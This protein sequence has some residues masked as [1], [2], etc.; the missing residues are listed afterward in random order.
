[1]PEVAA[2]IDRDGT[3]CRH[4]PYLSSV[5]NFEL[6][7]TAAPGVRRLN[8]AGVRTV[9][10]TNQ[11]GIGRGYFDRADADQIHERMVERLATADAQLDD[12]LLCPHHPD[13]NC[14]CRKPEPGLFLEAADT[15]DIALEE[16]FVVGDRRSDLEAGRRLGCTTILFPS[17]ETA[18]S[19]GEIESDYTVSRF[20]DA[21]GII[22]SAVSD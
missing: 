13:A 19:P 17:P 14:D 11:S 15:H 22:V 4:V 9:V 10:V 6:L 5:E 20:D 3:L 16:S 7:P 12:I 18:V 2:F 1:M 8:E 21:A